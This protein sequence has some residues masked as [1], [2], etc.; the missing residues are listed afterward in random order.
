MTDAPDT[1]P[2]LGHYEIAETLIV[3]ETESLRVLRITLAPDDIIPWHFHTTIDDR[4][5]CLEGTIEIET[6]APRALH[7]L[8]AGADR[9][10]GLRIDFLHLFVGQYVHGQPFLPFSWSTM[11]TSSYISPIS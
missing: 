8:Q 7:Q 3:A 1:R 5:F 10:D 9:I 6:R 11:S 4:F 2:W